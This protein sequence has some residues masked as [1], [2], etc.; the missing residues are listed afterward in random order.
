MRYPR[1]RQ[2]PHAVGW[3]TG[4]QQANQKDRPTGANGSLSVVFEKR[5][6]IEA[7]VSNPT[8]L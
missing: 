2:I 5:H 8:G 7:S 6:N 4:A 3:P 1:A